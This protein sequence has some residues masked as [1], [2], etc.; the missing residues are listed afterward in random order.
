MTSYAEKL[1]RDAEA[2]RRN[3]PTKSPTPVHRAV[4]HIPL[5]AQLE[6]LV[7]TVPS[8]ELRR[9]WHMDEFVSRLEGKY[10]ERPH[11]RWVGKALREIG[12]SQQRLWAAEWGGRRVWVAPKQS[13][14]KEQ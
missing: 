7:R 2:M 11:P 12:W 3:A 1:I 13:N 8:G 5:I 14:L 9:P 10:R 4:N 6:R